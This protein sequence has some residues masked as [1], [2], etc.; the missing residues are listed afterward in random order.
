MGQI[1]NQVHSGQQTWPG[2]VN[3]LTDKSPNPVEAEA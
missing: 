2:K 1:G 3:L